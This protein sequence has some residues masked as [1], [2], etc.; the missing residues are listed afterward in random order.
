MQSTSIA[1]TQIWW[2]TEVPV[3]E[4]KRHSAFSSWSARIHGL[5]EPIFIPLKFLHLPQERN[6]ASSQT[7]PNLWVPINLQQC[8]SQDA[9]FFWQLHMHEPNF[10]GILWFGSVGNFDSKLLVSKSVEKCLL[11]SRTCLLVHEV[12]PL[13]ETR[14]ISCKFEDIVPI[15]SSTQSYQK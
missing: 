13:W 14:Y 15:P 10:P 9:W 8:L 11:C 6:L 7:P 2:S 12:L 3:G 1:L 4:I 5:Q